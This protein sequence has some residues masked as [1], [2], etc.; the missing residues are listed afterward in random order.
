MWLFNPHPLSQMFYFLSR[1]VFKDKILVVAHWRF[2]A[3]HWFEPCRI[4]NGRS[5]KDWIYCRQLRKYQKSPDPDDYLF[6]GFLSKI[7][8]LKATGQPLSIYLTAPDYDVYKLVDVSTVISSGVWVPLSKVQFPCPKA[9]FPPPEFHTW[10]GVEISAKK[11]NMGDNCRN[12]RFLGVSDL[13]SY[14][15]TSDSG[16]ACK[17]TLENVPPGLFLV[18]F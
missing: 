8:P 9:R 18:E 10:S 7:S 1:S 17:F 12:R 2:N 15:F 16:S 5:K 13:K 4:R 6:Y 11:R 3:E 14:F